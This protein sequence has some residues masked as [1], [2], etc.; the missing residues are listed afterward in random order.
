LKLAAAHQQPTRTR[1]SSPWQNVNRL[2]G[3]EFLRIL[4]PSPRRVSP[5]IP[6]ETGSE[7][8][9][10]PIR[11]SFIRSVPVAVLPSPHGPYAGGRRAEI[12]RC[13]GPCVLGS[14]ITDIA[15]HTWTSRRGSGVIWIEIHRFTGL[16]I[17]D[18]LLVMP[19]EKPPQPRRWVPLSL[20]AY[21]AIL[22]ILG[23][24]GVV[25]IGIQANR[26]LNAIHEIQRRASG[27]SLIANGGP[28]PPLPL[29][30]G[31][32]FPAFVE[33]Q[34]VEFSNRPVTDD[35]VKVFHVL[36]E[37]A[38]LNLENTQITDVGLGYLSDL[39]NLQWL[40][41]DHTSVTDR[42]LLKL[43][44]LRYLEVLDLGHTKITDAGLAHLRRLKFLHDVDLTGT[45]VTDAGVAELKRSLPGLKI[46]R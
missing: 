44:N 32:W 19:D 11:L 38:I 20:R 35:D 31:R 33:V 2:F 9:D 7:I 43:V 8:P 40:R 17:D 41:L 34:H 23:T 18:T 30:F 29:G 10:F 28:N 13:C 24:A 39:R 3:P 27:V 16:G 46:K 15:A 21:L 25:G 14:A 26:R 6:Y 36:N 45:Q 5:E 1:L 4:R 22:A 12:Y 37:V 42:G